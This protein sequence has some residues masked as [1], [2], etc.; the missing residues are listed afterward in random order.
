MNK[1]PTIK[2][3]LQ[4]TTQTDFVAQFQEWASIRKVPPNAKTTEHLFLHLCANDFVE[5]ME[6][7]YAWADQGLSV[8][9]PWKA[10][11][12]AARSPEMLDFFLARHKVRKTDEL[13]LTA[14]ALNNVVMFETLFAHIAHN[15]T[16][17]N[18]DMPQIGDALFQQGKDKHF[19]I[20][21]DRM[22]ESDLNYFFK[23]AVLDDRRPFI[24]LLYTPER[25]DQINKMIETIRSVMPII[26][27]AG[28]ISYFQQ[29]A[30]RKTA[31]EQRDV[32]GEAVGEQPVR[33]RPISKM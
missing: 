5:G 15:N 29:V 1:A 32:L 7:V 10:G 9:T 28:G 17:I 31:E 18:A 13:V 6:V 33:A 11:M 25:R 19:G 12:R 4:C 26:D 30:Q 16:N 22:P 2:Q 20:I 14:E 23:K 24:D 27:E 21:L 8:K 3:V